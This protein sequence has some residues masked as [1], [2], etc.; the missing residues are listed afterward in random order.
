MRAA[1]R[2]LALATLGVVTAAVTAAPAAAEDRDGGGGLTVTVDAVTFDPS[3]LRDASGWLGYVVTRPDGSH[4]RSLG[5]RYSREDAADGVLE[6]DVPRR[7]PYQDG[8]CISWVLVTGIDRQFAG[9]NGD[10]AVCTTAAASPAPAPTTPPTTP[11]PAPSTEAPTQAPPPADA[12]APATEEPREP[13]VAPEPETT[14]EPTPDPT[15]EAPVEPTPTAEPSTPEPEPSRTPL[16]SVAER[17]PP[18]PPAAESFPVFAVVGVGG[19][20]AAAAGGAILLLRR[21]G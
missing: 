9:W 21:V 19:L 20:V 18:P 11:S 6:L 13:V 15:T 2:L 16:V 17:M 7:G 12:P 1:G 4:V 10:A 8:Y 5:D 14:E 3:R